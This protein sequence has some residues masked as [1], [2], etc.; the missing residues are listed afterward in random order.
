VQKNRCVNLAL[1]ACLAAVLAACGDDG[2]DQAFRA[3]RA[4]ALAAEY[5][6]RRNVPAAAN[7]PK[8]TSPGST[9]SGSTFAGTGPTGVVISV[10]ALDNFFR[11]E[12]LTIQV[13]DEVLWENNGRN[14]HNILSVESADEGFEAD[15]AWGID[16]EGFQPGAV[17]SHVFTEPG[18]YRYYCTVHGSAEVGMVGT[19][20]V[21]A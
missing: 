10:I 20:T 1:A 5:R 18:N 3:E 12:Q 21:E 15:G 2:P 4:A 13:G 9:S 7:P 14:E 16:V 8:S 11:P 6:S 17:F 19:I